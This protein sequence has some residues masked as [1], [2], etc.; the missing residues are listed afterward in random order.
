MSFS[1]L[2]D[3]EKIYSFQYTAAQWLELKAQ[4]NWLNLR[5]PCCGASAILK[6]SSLGTQFFAHKSKQDQNCH[7]SDG[8][9]AEHIFAKYLVSKALYEEGWQVETE[10]R[11]QTDDGQLWVADIYAEH[12]EVS[13][14]M[15]VEIQWSAQSY[16]QTAYR[17]SLYEKSNLRCVWLLRNGRQR[18][19]ADALTGHYAQRTKFL[20][21]FTLIKAEDKSFRVHNIYIQPNG[22]EA[23]QAISMEL[24]DFIKCLF[25]KGLEF[26]PRGD[27][28][29][30]L[31]LTLM[32]NQCCYCKKDIVVVGRVNHYKLHYG[33]KISLLHNA[34]VRCVSR[35]C[36][37]LI[38]HV[39][40]PLYNFAEV[41]LRKNKTTKALYI[42]N[43]CIYCDSAMGSL[44]EDIGFGKYEHLET[45]SLLIEEDFDNET[46]QWFLKRNRIDIVRYEVTDQLLKP[47]ISVVLQ[48]RFDIRYQ[49]KRDFESVA[50]EHLA[51]LIE[52]IKIETDLDI[53]NAKIERYFPIRKD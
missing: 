43:A 6:T 15:V 51:T 22:N 47:D 41:K 50:E 44:M 30:H 49:W 31:S 48:N 46:G 29:E 18:K 21:V 33:Q 32:K 3:G 10:K 19:A 5:M 24:T 8:E 20:P 25:S 42:A 14:G 4:R 23:P 45:S 52:D 27:C 11:G 13:K 35:D 12:T 9:S 26:T 2:Q 16:E 1:C 53:L 36:R 34:T 38:N 40:R 37:E 39:F 17:Q 7:A 28:S